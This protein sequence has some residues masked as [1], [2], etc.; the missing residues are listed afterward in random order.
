ML[1]LR[2][3]FLMDINETKRLIR[4]RIEM[5][6]EE[7]YENER[8][9]GFATGAIEFGDEVLNLVP[10]QKEELRIRS[11]HDLKEIRGEICGLWMTMIDRTAMFQVIIDAATKLTFIASIVFLFFKLH[12]VALFF[13]LYSLLLF[14]LTKTK[15]IFPTV[16]YVL[17]GSFII[18]DKLLVSYHMYGRMEASIYYADYRNFS[19]IDQQV[20]TWVFT[21][22]HKKSSPA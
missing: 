16:M 20:D 2:R 8:I 18:S 22:S 3:L 7:C 21:T 5:M 11:L 15:T 17:C 9:N 13:F 14:L 19:H 12:Y 4:D 6:A 10:M 1:D